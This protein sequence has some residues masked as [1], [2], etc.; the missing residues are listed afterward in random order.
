MNRTQAILL[1]T[2]TPN[3]DPLRMGPC[4]AI[5]VGDRAY[6]VD[7]GA[8]LVRRAHEAFTQG[9]AALDVKNLDRL[10]LTHLHS[11]HTV[12]LPDLIFSPWVMGRAL[13]LQVHGPK[14]TRHLVDQ[15]VSAYG[16]DVEARTCGLEPINSTG[17]SAQAFEIDAGIVFEDD[18]VL[19]EAFG[20]EH[21]TTWEPLGYKFTTAERT[22]VVSGDTAPCPEVYDL[23]QDCDLLIHEVYSAAGFARRAPHWQAYHSHMHTSGLELG[24][25][26]QRVRPKLLVLTHLLLWGET[27]EALVAE[28]KQSF[29]GAVQCG[30]DLGVY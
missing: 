27:P 17:G 2:G 10:F 18:R 4:T 16:A 11:D 20:V 22:I 15:V 9:I 8:G 3:P 19:V 29:D 23:W 25:I 24:E 28:V 30:V 5:T 7:C 12:G 13:P 26:A 6:L 14:G 1:G 21:G